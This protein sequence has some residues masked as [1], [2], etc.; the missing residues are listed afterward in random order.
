[1]RFPSGQPWWQNGT[2]HSMQRAPWCC[3]STSG[4]VR[5]N[6]RW[7]PTRSCG[8]RSSCSARENFLKPPTS[9]TMRLLVLALA[10]EEPVPAGRDRLVAVLLERGAVVVRHHL[11]EA[12]LRRLPVVEQPCGD[13]GIGAA[14][15]LVQQLTQEIQ[16]LVLE[17]LEADELLVAA[18]LERPVLVEHVGDPAAHSRSEVAAGAA[19]YEYDAARHVL[20]AVIADA[21]DDR[22]R[23]AVANGEPLA[24]ETAEERLAR[25]RPVQD[26]VSCD[27]VLLCRERCALGRA[28]RKCPAGE[29]FTDVVIRLAEERQL[30]SRR[31]PGTERLT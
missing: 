20:A 21:L 15:V 29:A 27:D 8:S 25:R 19:D 24:D 28:E 31:E 11:H 18:L 2:P 17:G 22:R 7:S 30:D 16:I 6:S 12:E 1:M 9:P 3:S 4:S 5:T 10:R 26:R 13:D 14:L 23:S